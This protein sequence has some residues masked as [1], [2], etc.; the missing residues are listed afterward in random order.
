V[1]AAQ[2]FDPSSA[3]AAEKPRLK[4]NIRLK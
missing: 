2:V 1:I 3:A 4:M